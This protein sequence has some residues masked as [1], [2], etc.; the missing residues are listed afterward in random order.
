MLKT[1]INTLKQ[2]CQ[3]Y[4]KSMVRRLNKLIDSTSLLKSQQTFTIIWR[5]SK[6]IKKQFKKRFV[7]KNKLIKEKFNLFKLCCVVITVLKILK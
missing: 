6:N 7:L 3:N 1:L 5:L 2:E 4:E